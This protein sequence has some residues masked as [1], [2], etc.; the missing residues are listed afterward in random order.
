MSEAQ[1]PALDATHTIADATALEKLFT[2]RYRGAS[3]SAIEKVLVPVPVPIR[4]IDPT[5]RRLSGC[6][7]RSATFTISTDGAWHELMQPG[8]T[9]KFVPG[10]Y[11]TGDGVWR[12]IAKGRLL[13]VDHAARIA[14]GEI[15][16]GTKSAEAGLN[17]ALEQLSTADFWEIDQYGASAKV[18][19]GLVEYSL[20]RKAVAEGFVVRRM[21][22]DVAKHIGAYYSYDFEF[23]KD[24]VSK[25]VEVKSLWGTDTTCARLIHSKTNG[26]PTSSCKFATQDIFA[27]SLFL[28]TGDIND[29]AFAR[30]VSS[31][32][33]TYGLPPA[34]K[35]PEHVSQNP[36]CAIGNGA[37][38]GSIKEVWELA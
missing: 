20:A 28:R 16:L 38:Y 25:K 5:I 31:A 13:E 8:C 14:T 3:L 32:N 12:E 11:V 37:W 26:Y 36:V 27:V 33:Q 34:A 4:S 23:E 1:S 18:L 2:K 22:A 19:S 29:F 17:A 9:G 6:S 7:H 21:P 15:Y 10:E 24:G 30:S 35:Y